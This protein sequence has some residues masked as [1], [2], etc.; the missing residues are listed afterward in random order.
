MATPSTSFFLSKAIFII[1]SKNNS[2]LSL[3]VLKLDFSKITPSS[4]NIPHLIFVPPISKAKYFFINQK[5]LYFNIFFINFNLSLYG[6]NLKGN[7]IN[8]PLFKTDFL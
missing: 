3:L 5:P 2:S 4:F 1:F 8:V 6:A 7:S